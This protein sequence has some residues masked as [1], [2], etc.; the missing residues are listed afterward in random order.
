MSEPQMPEWV[1]LISTS[2]SSQGLGS[3]SFQTM[4]PSAAL[5]SSPI[6]PSNL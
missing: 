5:G 1:I 3:Y 4:W 2:D 6:Q